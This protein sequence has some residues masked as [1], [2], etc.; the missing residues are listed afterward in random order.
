L[1]IINNERFYPNSGME[2]LFKKIKSHLHENQL[3]LADSSGAPLA[4]TEIINII[5]SNSTYS[6]NSISI[7]EIEDGFVHEMLEYVEKVEKY[8]SELS[9]SS[10]SELIINTFIDLINSLTE[11][12]KVAN[13]YE[14]Y[15]I[16]IDNINEIANKAVSRI[17]A[18]DI[19]FILD[20]MEYEIIPSLLDFKSKL[21]ERQHH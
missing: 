12:I 15:F 13:Y 10:N 6:F 1:Y 14:F 21:I 7:S 9:I 4:E 19:D 20:I 5:T 18:G 11:I 2:N 3:V 16:S 17:E 8:F